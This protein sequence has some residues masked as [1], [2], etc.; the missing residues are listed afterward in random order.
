MKTLWSP[1][2]D[3]IRL[4]YVF[5]TTD[6]VLVRYCINYKNYIAHWSKESK[7]VLHI[8]NTIEISENG[9][10]IPTP[11]GASKDYYIGFVHHFQIGKSL[12]ENGFIYI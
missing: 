5:E 8:N 3:Y 11:F 4:M 2:S 12:L 9:M 6:G 7:Q 10:P 1:D